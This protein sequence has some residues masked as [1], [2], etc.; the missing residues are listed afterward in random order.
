MYGIKPP[1]DTIAMLDDVAAYN[2]I[3]LDGPSAT[4]SP[5]KLLQVT[6]PLACTPQAGTPDVNW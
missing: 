3:V 6:F 4:G 2:K 5:N 1:A